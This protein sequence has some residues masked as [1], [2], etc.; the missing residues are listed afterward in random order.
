MFSIKTNYHITV[1]CFLAAISFSSCA[2]LQ[3]DRK[4]ANISKLEKNDFGL[5]LIVYPALNPFSTKMVVLLSGDGGWLDFDHELA[6]HFSD[7]GFNTVG[8]NSRS[9]FWEQKTPEQTA[10]DLKLLIRR[11]SS[12]WKSKKIVLCGYS[13]GADVTPFIY[14]RLP[15]DIKNKVEA[16]VLLSP[17]LSTDFV[18]N[19][20]DSDSDDKPYKVKSELEKI[21]IPVYCFYG[22]EEDPKSLDDF[23]QH[24]FSI[25]LVPGDHHYQDAYHQ[26][27]SSVAHIK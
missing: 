6:K 13:F 19:L 9:Y 4:I 23:K 12:L 27:V 3:K 18:V 20:Y 25:K 8:F 22:K 15:A 11:Y 5:P 10:N 17:F 16:L 26:I 21:M 7:R 24:N 2:I 1:F 14:N